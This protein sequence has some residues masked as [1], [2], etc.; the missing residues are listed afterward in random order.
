MQ[1]EKVKPSAANVKVIRQEEGSTHNI[2]NHR[3]SHVGEKGQERTRE[4]NRDVMIG[5]V[6][7]P[8]ERGNKGKERRLRSSR[9]QDT[10]AD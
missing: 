3:T 1:N 10:K 2:T 5:R 8:Q 4:G 9:A 7:E 6:T